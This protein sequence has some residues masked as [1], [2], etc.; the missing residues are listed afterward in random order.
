MRVV[1]ETGVS[2]RRI[3]ADGCDT[4]ENLPPTSDPWDSKSWEAN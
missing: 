2:V 4:L 1:V 3:V